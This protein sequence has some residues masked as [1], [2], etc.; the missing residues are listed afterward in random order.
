MINA[1]N[2]Q[3]AYAQRLRAVIAER[4]S[5]REFK[6]LPADTKVGVQSYQPGANVAQ[7]R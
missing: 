5:I 1:L 2:Q 3:P 6:F 4:V 7:G